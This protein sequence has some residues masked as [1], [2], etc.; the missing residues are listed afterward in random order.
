MSKVKSEKEIEAEKLAIEAARFD[1]EVKVKYNSV[2]KIETGGYKAYF[3]KPNRYVTGNFVSKVMVN[4]AVAYEEL[5]QCCVIKEVSDSEIFDN[6]DLF[7]SCYPALSGLTNVK[8][9]TSTIL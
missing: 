6:D 7:Q 5:Y 3:T 8:K 2:L 9:S 1:E 4:M